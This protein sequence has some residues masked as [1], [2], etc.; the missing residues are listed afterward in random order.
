MM[1]L[2]NVATIVWVRCKCTLYWIDAWG[3]LLCVFNPAIFIFSALI[4]HTLHCLNANYLKLYQF[5]GCVF[6]CRTFFLLCTVRYCNFVLY[7]IVTL[8]YATGLL[9]T[10]CTH[11]NQ[12]KKK[13]STLW[14]ER[15][16]QIMVCVDARNSQSV[17][18]RTILLYTNV[19]LTLLQ[20]SFYNV[21]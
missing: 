13:W 6:R 9:C 4:G 8:W 17:C 2:A 1:R 16:R 18:K 15:Q 21:F 19:F 5:Q 11:L 12:K 14:K 7:V 3:K 10:F 20:S